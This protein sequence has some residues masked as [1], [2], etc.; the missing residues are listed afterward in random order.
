M[1]PP[2]C[3]F[4]TTSTLSHSVCGACTPRMDTAHKQ[5]PRSHK[6][7]KSLQHPHLQPCIAEGSTSS[8]GHKG[9]SRHHYFG[10]HRGTGGSEHSH[11]L[12]TQWGLLPLT[13]ITNCHVLTS[14]RGGSSHWVLPSCLVPNTRRKWHFWVFPIIIPCSNT[15]KSFTATDEG[16]AGNSPSS[17]QLQRNNTKWK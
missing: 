10:Q 5:N 4:P 14:G 17:W 7:G 1:L 12:Q 6:S 9:A 16:T 3:L 13:E 8:L 15:S 2:Q 11:Q